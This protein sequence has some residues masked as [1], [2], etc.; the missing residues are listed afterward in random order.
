[1]LVS[2]LKNQNFR[3]ACKQSGVF[4]YEVAERLGV[5]EATL[6][7]ALRKELP[8]KDRIAVL[9]AVKAIA[10]ERMKEAAEDVEY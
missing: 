5:S 8:A 4:Q 9:E 7:K 1:M 10:E 2:N 6:S 3:M